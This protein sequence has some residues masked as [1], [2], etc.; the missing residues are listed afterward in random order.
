MSMRYALDITDHKIALI[1]GRGTI[2]DPNH[3]QI[4]AADGKQAIV[5]AKNIII[6]TGSRPK[7]PDIP[8]AKKYGISSDDF[9]TL[10]EPPGKT[11]IVGGSYIALETAGILTGLGF[12]VTVMVRGQQ[13]LRSFDQTCVGF[14]INH[15]AQSGTKFMFNSS[16]NSV[17]DKH[18]SF[19]TKSG[20]KTEDFD[21]I[22]FAIGRVPSSKNIGLENVNIQTDE[23][24]RIIVDD[25]DCSSVKNIYAIGDVSTNG[26]E[27]TPV[28]ILA[29][30]LLANR[31]FG[32]STLKMDYTN[33][34]TTVFTP[35]E[36][37]SVG[38]SEVAARALHGD[39]LD[40][41]N[42]V[43]KNI[44]AMGFVKMIVKKSNGKVLGF[45][46]VGENAG[47]VTQGVAVAI[48]AGVTKSHFDET[49]SIHPTGAGIMTN[50]LLGETS[51][52]T[53]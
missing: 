9:F 10:K 41:Y 43:F 16:V 20:E 26:D 22:M 46:F 17:Q 36:Y 4:T 2:I 33:V 39:D 11:L 34:P 49:V 21:T 35:M 52:F 37:G 45:H 38:L 24:G 12:D 31:L 29:G 7:F 40:V 47:E 51:D 28:A 27:L 19:T 5:H 8:G 30:R 3:V 42:R 25:S 13:V 18:V 53:C 15:M 23:R 32:Q 50:L 6:A 1:N 14:A 48:K 44:S